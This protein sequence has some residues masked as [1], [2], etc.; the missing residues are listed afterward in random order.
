ML[1]KLLQQVEHFFE[2]LELL[3]DRL[4]LAVGGHLQAES[5]WEYLERVLLLFIV[6][7]LEVLEK[8]ILGGD[9]M[10]MLE[11][12][13][14]L[15]KAVR[16]AFEINRFRNRRPSKVE[17]RLLVIRHLCPEVGPGLLHNALD[18]TRIVA[19]EDLIFE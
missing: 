4:S 8:F 5:Q 2:G 3:F 16:Q 7:G 17:V 1:L 15:A 12:V 10:M 11:V 9:F 19:I 14:R 18:K 13:C 6:V